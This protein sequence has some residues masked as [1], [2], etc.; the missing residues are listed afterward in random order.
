MQVWRD[1]NVTA[2]TPAAD[3]DAFGMPVQTA[4]PDSSGPL[5]LIA[6]YSCEL[7]QDQKRPAAEDDA[8]KQPESL[9]RWTVSVLEADTPNIQLGDTLLCLGHTLRVLDPSG[10]GTHNVIRLVRCMEILS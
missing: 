3:Q 10:P 4:A 8:G 6:T 7:E 5:T 2:G 1:P 9:L